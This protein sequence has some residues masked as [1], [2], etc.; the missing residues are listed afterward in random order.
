M[1]KYECCSYLSNEV[2]NRISPPDDVVFMRDLL[3]QRNIALEE[4]LI[5]EETHH[6]HETSF[7]ARASK[8]ISRGRARSRRKKKL[9]S[10]SEPIT[11]DEITVDNNDPIS[12]VPSTPTSSPPVSEPSS[13]RLNTSSL[14]NSHSPVRWYSSASAIQQGIISQSQSPRSSPYQRSPSHHGVSSHPGPSHQNKKFVFKLTKSSLTPLR[15]KD[16]IIRENDKGKGKMIE[17]ESEDD[18]KKK[19]I[20]KS[21]MLKALCRNTV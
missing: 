9:E 21:R 19:G 16:T 13:P 1:A 14:G 8:K 20:R 6:H 5:E 12:S 4:A 10:S 2:F 15:S 11:S 17:I 3:E 7:I 18:Q